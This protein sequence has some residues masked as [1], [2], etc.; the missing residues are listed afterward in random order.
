VYF[1]LLVSTRSSEFSASFHGEVDLLCPVLHQAHY[2]TNIQQADANILKP[3]P[4]A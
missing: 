2:V 4:F 3:G 1:V